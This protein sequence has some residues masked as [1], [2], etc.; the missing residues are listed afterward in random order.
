MS[1]WHEPSTRDDFYDPYYYEDHSK[2]D[3]VHIDDLPDLDHARDHMKAVLAALY[4]TGTLDSLEN[5]LE[6]VLAILDMKLP[7]GTLCIYKGTV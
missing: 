6:E 7:A 2:D 4:G 3:Y 5:S 1:L